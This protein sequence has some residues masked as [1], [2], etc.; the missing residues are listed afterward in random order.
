M[1]DK[2]L[3]DI[4]RREIELQRSL[5]EEVLPEFYSEDYPQ[6]ISFLKS[7][8]NF[9]DSDNGFS[10]KIY[11]LYKNR[12]VQQTP[13]EN[14]TFIEDELLLGKNYLE[15]WLNTRQ[16]AALSNNFYRSKGTK[17]SIER[18]FRSFYGV[19]PVVEY[20]KNYVFTVGQDI[21]G[22]NSGKYII[23]DKVYQF[24]GILIKVGIPS[25]EWLQLYKL[26]AHPAGMYV[27]SEVQIIS[28]NDDISFDNM[29]ISVPS[30]DVPVFSG[31][32]RLI[33]RAYTDLTSIDI[34]DSAGNSI[35]YTLDA[36]VI[37][38]QNKLQDQTSG[39]L[40]SATPFIQNFGDLVKAGSPTFDE[41]SDVN[42]S[43]MRMSATFVTFDVNKYGLNADS[44]GAGNLS[45]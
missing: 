44:D 7:Y 24:W 1:T 14:L 41:D 9:M 19:D 26:F 6:L 45:V 30:V 32:A 33:P 16:A 29:P 23:N 2:T 25:S 39:F 42:A 17:Y 36:T 34:G 5:V 4:G 43:S 15:G 8:Y 35:R 38:I 27:G 31:L 11:D 40:D 13:E 28:I 21:I 22:P 12:D 18:F 37:G 3:K 20:G 10:T